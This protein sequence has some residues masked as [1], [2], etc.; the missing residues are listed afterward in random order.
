LN[1]W[2]DEQGAGIAKLIMVGVKYT[3]FYLPAFSMIDWQNDSMFGKIDR[4][5]ELRN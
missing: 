2:Q 3:D 1:V 4:T 5:H